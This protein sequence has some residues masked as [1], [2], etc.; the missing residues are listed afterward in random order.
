M[1]LSHFVLIMALGLAPAGCY[2]LPL[3]RSAPLG[4]PD[5]KITLEDVPVHGFNVEASMASGDR[6]ETVTGELLAAEPEILYLFKEGQT[7]KIPRSDLRKVEL[8]ELFPSGAAAMG[9]WTALGTA[10]SAS[11][12]L[13]AM[14][15]MPIWLVTGIS[16]SVAAALGNDL[17]VPLSS[18]DQLYQ[19]A[20]YPQGM[21]KPKLSPVPPPAP[22]IQPLP[23]PP[24]AVEPAPAPEPQ[25]APEP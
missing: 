16:L 4:K 13:Y 7:L 14:Y 2:H 15:S 18:Y 5:T 8:V 3:D 20:R 23:V 12:G 19:F 9:I 24:I 10:S 25:P 1:R 17:V 11:H 21:P 6:S 22:E